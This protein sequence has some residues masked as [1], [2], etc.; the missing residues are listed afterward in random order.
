MLS[1]LNCISSQRRCY[2][3]KGFQNAGRPMQQCKLIF[4]LGINKVLS[5]FM[6]FVRRTKLEHEKTVSS[7]GSSEQ[8]QNH[9]PAAFGRSSLQKL[10]EGFPD[11]KQLLFQFNIKMHTIYTTFYHQH[12]AI[13]MWIPFKW[14][15]TN[16]KRFFTFA[17]TA[18][19]YRQTSPGY[20]SWSIQTH[21]AW[22]FIRTRGTPGSS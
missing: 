19:N 5:Y 4:P 1:C 20:Q 17:P 13:E 2:L 6:L 11:C 7:L 10:R 3:L 14:A 21:Q 9:N 16:Y 12:W 22:K 18:N 8:K 15:P